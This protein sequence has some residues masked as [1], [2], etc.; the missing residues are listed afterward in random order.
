MQMRSQQTVPIVWDQDAHR[1]GT[2][3]K[4]LEQYKET[5]GKMTY[6][7]KID[8]IARG[9]GEHDPNVPEDLLQDAPSSEQSPLGEQGRNEKKIDAEGQES[10][11]NEPSDQEKLLFPGKKGDVKGL[12]EI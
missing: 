11:N 10:H 12:E 6:Q 3:E 9:N 8:E 5:E 7:A 4:D 2:D 1:Y